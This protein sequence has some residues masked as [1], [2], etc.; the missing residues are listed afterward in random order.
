MPKSTPPPPLSTPNSSQETPPLTHQSPPTIGCFPAPP[1]PPPKGAT[2]NT[3]PPVWKTIAHFLLTAVY[4]TTS[5]Q[6]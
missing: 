3:N 4:V 1:P 6:F 2:E 5:I